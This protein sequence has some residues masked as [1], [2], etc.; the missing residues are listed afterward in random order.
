[1]GP[2]SLTGFAERHG[3]ELTAERLKEIESDVR[4]AAYEVRRLK[5]ATSHAI[6]LAVAR[7]IRYLVREPGYL[8]PVSVRVEER[9][10][11]S[12]PAQIGS[13]GPGE[14]LMPA[15]SDDEQRA[16]ETSLAVIREANAPSDLRTTEATRVSRSGGGSLGTCSGGRMHVSSPRPTIPSFPND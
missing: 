9:L 15:L 12:L 8:V 5:G 4:R 2:F 14:P 10:C 11:A 16:W 1:M 7:L 3:R 6:G 13:D